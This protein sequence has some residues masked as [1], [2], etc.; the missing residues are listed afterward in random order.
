MSGLELLSKHS[1]T[2][3]SA[4][5]MIILQSRLRDGTRK[6]TII[7]EIVGMGVIRSMQDIFVYETEGK[8][9]KR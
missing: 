4:I 6:V 9:L 5:D 3:S 1:V 8:L 2:N 7:T